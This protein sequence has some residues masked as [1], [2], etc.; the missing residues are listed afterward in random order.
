[1]L[2]MFA[3]GGKKCACGGKGRV[4]ISPKNNAIWS[5]CY[6]VVA[7]DLMLSKMNKITDALAMYKYVFTDEAEL[8]SGIATALGQSDIDYEKEARLSDCDRLDFLVEKNIALEVKVD[9]SASALTRQ[10]HRYAQHESIEGII[11]V[12][13]LNRLT[14]LPETLNKK[15]IAIYHLKLNSL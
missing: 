10:V 1:M 2:E 14:D 13:N 11:V 15:P 8:Q 6:C 4:K 9:G 3:T 7:K 5:I 12:T